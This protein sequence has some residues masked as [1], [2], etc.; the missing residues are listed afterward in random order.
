MDEGVIYR[1]IQALVELLGRVQSV[2][3]LLGIESLP[4]KCQKATSF[5][6]RGIILTTSLYLE[7]GG[8]VEEISSE[9]GESDDVD[10]DSGDDVV[11]DGDDGDD[12]EN[13]EDIITSARNLKI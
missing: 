1:A 9:E 11:I 4:E 8:Y 13:E 10:D 7:P 12:N 6:N 2:A 5:I 3:D